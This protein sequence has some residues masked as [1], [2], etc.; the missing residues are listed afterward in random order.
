MKIAILEDDLMLGELI[1]EHLSANNQVILFSNGD[2]I[3]E[4]IYDN[5]IDLLLLD[6]NVPGLKGD[7]LLK[8]IR[9]NNNKTPVIFI[10]SQTSSKDIKNGFELGCD[11]YIKKPFEFEELDARIEYI[12]KVYNIEQIVEVNGY[13]FD[14]ERNILKKDKE[15]INLTP[16]AS[17][18]LNYLIKN[19]G[20]VVS[21]DELIE[22]LWGDDIPTESTLRTYIKMLRRIF[23]NIK[24]YRG[25]GYEFE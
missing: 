21:K 11:D 14:V 19:R 25:S 5:K 24:T 9:S 6:I 23:P 3:E 10:T 15:L 17:L 13:I 20:K 4:Y 8:N 22:N 16:K 2:E 18:V 1:K 7:K 12:K